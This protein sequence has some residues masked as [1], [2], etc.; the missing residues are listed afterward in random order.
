[1][2]ACPALRDDGCVFLAA[3]GKPQWF[4]ADSGTTGGRVVAQKRK[5]PAMPA[6]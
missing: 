2:D 5:T 4:Q 6:F 3:I 1:L